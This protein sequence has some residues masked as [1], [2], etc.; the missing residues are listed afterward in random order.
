MNSGGSITGSR[1]PLSNQRVTRFD[2]RAIA[3]AAAVPTTT[4]IAAVARA[5]VALTRKPVRNASSPKISRNHRSESPCGGQL[6]FA[7]PLNPYSD[8]DQQRQVDEQEQAA[9]PSW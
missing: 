8:D 9:R 2:R 1:D 7:P 3:K 5:A 6:R 4:A